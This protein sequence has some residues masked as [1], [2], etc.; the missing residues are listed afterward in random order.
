MLVVAKL[1]FVIDIFG[2][3]PA[4]PLSMQSTLVVLPKEF[5]LFC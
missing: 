1:I 2:L 3:P 4:V 5:G